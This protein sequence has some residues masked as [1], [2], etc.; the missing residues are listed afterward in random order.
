MYAYELRLRFVRTYIKDDKIAVDV[1][2]NEAIQYEVQ[3]YV[4]QGIVVVLNYRIEMRKKSFI[5]SETIVS[6][7]FQKK[8]YYDFFNEEYVLSSENEKE[9]RSKTFNNLLKNLY[10]ARTVY[11]IDAN[12]INDSSEY[13]YHTR[14]SMRFIN[15]YPYLSIFFNLITPLRYRIKWMNSGYF[16]KSDLK[17]Y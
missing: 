14:L 7:Y 11:V 12:K 17:V 5:L 9:I 15:A 8:I 16:K 3:D 2:M 10:N 4:S 6:L 1:R 13:Y